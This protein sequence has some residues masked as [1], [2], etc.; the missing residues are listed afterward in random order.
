MMDVI[1]QLLDIIVAVV[2]ALDR[3]DVVK[4]RRSNLGVLDV[5]EALALVHGDHAKR[6]DPLADAMVDDL[7]LPNQDFAAG[8]ETA[9]APAGTECLRPRETRSLAMIWY[10]FSARCAQVAH[11]SYWYSDLLRTP[12]DPLQV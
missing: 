9:S 10:I 1:E 11:G 4:S 12:S 2:V 8:M 7:L 5:E 6:S 3:I